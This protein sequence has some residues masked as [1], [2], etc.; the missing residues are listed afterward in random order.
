MF[1]LQ[2]PK[3]INTF[4]RDTLNKKASKLEAFFGFVLVSVF[5]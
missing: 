2:T 5:N 4:R 1:L 3:C